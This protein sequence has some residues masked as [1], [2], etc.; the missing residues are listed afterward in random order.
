MQQLSGN[1]GTKRHCGA[2]HLEGTAQGKSAKPWTHRHHR[3]RRGRETFTQQAQ[4]NPAP[5]GQQVLM[6]KPTEHCGSSIQRMIMP[7]VQPVSASSEHASVRRSGHLVCRR[8]R[9]RTGI[10]TQRERV[11]THTHTPAWLVL[12]L[13][14]SFSPPPPVF[15]SAPSQLSWWERDRGW[16]VNE[17]AGYAGNYF[18]WSMT[19]RNGLENAPTGGFATVTKRN[20]DCI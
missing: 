11:H 12:P 14:F 5:G 20:V 9:R 16:T 13:L 6:N 3:G 7:A 2:I 17:L 8:S 18:S 1:T 4:Q 15:S 19:H 10:N